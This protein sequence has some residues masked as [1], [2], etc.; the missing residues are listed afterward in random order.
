MKR[1]FVLATII[2]CMCLA[3]NAEVT[4]SRTKYAGCTVVK[5]VDAN[6]FGT[7]TTYGLEI[8]GKTILKPE[9]EMTYN[10]DLHLVAFTYVDDVMYRISVYSTDSGKC[11]YTGLWRAN[12]FTPYVTYSKDGKYV[13]AVLNHHEYFDNGKTVV[14]K[15]YRKD[16]KTYQYSTKQVIYDKKL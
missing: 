9:C 14:G 11:V 3:A 4:I 7:L 8:K 6:F 13:N 12:S 15:F 16:G 1:I 2:C 5:R 10:A